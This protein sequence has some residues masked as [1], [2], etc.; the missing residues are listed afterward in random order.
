MNVDKNQSRKFPVIG[1]NQK[2]YI[3]WDVL[4]PHEKQALRNH[5][6]QSLECLAERGGLSWNEI[7]PILKDKTWREFPMLPDNEA[8][9]IVLEYVSEW[10]TKKAVQT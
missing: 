7:L 2:E 6:G 8:K 3:P 4:T 9:K 1:T 10:K 5:C